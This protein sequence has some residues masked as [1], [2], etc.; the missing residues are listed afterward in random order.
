MSTLIERVRS[1]ARSRDVE[2]ILVDGPNRGRCVVARAGPL[3]TLVIDSGTA[4]SSGYGELVYRA[5][6]AAADSQ[7]LTINVHHSVRSK[8]KS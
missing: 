7:R 3:T 6:E 1:Y 2:I 5:C 8:L 4:A